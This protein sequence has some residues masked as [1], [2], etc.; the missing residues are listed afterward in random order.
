MGA[1]LE[2]MRLAAILGLALLAACNPTAPDVRSQITRAQLD[3]VKEPLLLAEIKQ[4]GTAAGVTPLAQNGDVV[5]WQTGDRVT[6]SFRDGVLVGSRG[7]GQDL[8]SADVGNTLVA[9]RGGAAGYYP[10]FHS[11][12]DGEHQTQFRSFQCRITAR[13]PETIEIFERRHA[14]TRIEETCHSP[15]LEVVNRFWQGGGIMWKS[16]QWVS[17]FVGY[18]L[19]ER[20]V[21]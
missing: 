21:R 19:T 1:V 11:Y 16:Q 5:T 10:K 12:L 6:L 13:A 14:T 8:I 17:P 2:M 3:Q 15:G 9:L 7:L 18:L 4:L 20:L